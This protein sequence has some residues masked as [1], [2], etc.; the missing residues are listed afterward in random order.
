MAY[1]GK[2]VFFNNYNNFGEQ[3]LL[4]SLIIEALSIFG[5]EVIYIPRQLGEFDNLYTED[6]QSYYS[7]NTTIVAYIKNVDGFSGDGSFLSS[8][9]LQIRD[10][11]T[12]TISQ[13]IFSQDVAPL[14]G[15][16]RPNEGDLIYF[17][18]NNK[19]FVIK[20]ADKFNLFYTLGT[21]PTWDLVCEV[22]E[23]SD[24]VFKTGIPAID[25]IQSNLSTNVLDYVIYTENNNILIDENG[26]YITNEKDVISNII[27]TGANEVIEKESASV[28][29]WSVNDPFSEGYEG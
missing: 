3:N 10:Q 11:V 7:T 23:Y 21:L 26:N 28:I 16:I 12:F 5:E 2:N 25:S 9:G 6:S 4:H 18:L 22:F 1:G 20:Y 17:P 13:R 15:Q 19:C 24:E 14:I 27:K 8:F 29:D